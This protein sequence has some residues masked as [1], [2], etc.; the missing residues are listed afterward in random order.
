MGIKQSA[1]LI[2]V[3]GNRRPHVTSAESG[4]IADW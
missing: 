2:E 3:F 4:V 1:T